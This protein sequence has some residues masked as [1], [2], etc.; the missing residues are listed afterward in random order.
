MCQNTRLSFGEY[1]QY[2]LRYDSGD[3]SQR[4]GAPL[5]AWE[6]HPEWGWTLTEY[7]TSTGTRQLIDVVYPTEEY[8]NRNE[9]VRRIMTPWSFPY[10]SA[11]QR[12]VDISAFDTGNAEGDLTTNIFEY[13]VPFY[14]EGNPGLYMFTAEESDELTPTHDRS[15]RVCRPKRLRSSSLAIWTLTRNGTAS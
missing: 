2:V 10:M 15:S 5:G 7:E 8:I 11:N 9:F 4:F 3:N 13:L 14:H 1:A 6:E 12:I